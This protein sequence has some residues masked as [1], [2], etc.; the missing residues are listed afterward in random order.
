MQLALK[1]VSNVSDNR[2]RFRRSRVTPRSLETGRHDPGSFSW[3]EDLDE[4]LNYWYGLRR[5]GAITDSGLIEE[6]REIDRPPPLREPQ[7]RC[8]GNRLAGLSAGVGPVEA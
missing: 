6:V 3:T 7:T 2:W 8:S 5:E 4:T 1:L